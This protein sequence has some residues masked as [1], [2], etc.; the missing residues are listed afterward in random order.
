MI[1]DFFELMK[2]TLQDIQQFL[3]KEF[4]QSL[5]HCA[6]KEIFEGGARA[7]YLI[8]ADHLRPGGTVS[9]PSM[10]TIA[11]FAMYVA[12]LGQVGLVALAVTSNINIHFLRKP[13]A[14]RNLK[15]NYQMRFR[16]KHGR[17]PTWA[18][19]MAH[20]DAHVKKMWIDALA[21]RGVIVENPQETEDGET[22]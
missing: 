6:V 3:E 14:G 7:T 15:A 9:G 11:D 17:F 4:P 18:D 12:V 1:E 16:Q 10:F 22:E 20:C 5:S 13:V 19:A 8:Q 21:E 2:A